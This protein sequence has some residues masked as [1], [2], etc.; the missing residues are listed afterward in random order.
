MAADTGSSMQT[1]IDGINRKLDI[2]LEELHVQRQAREQLEDLVDDLSIVG[3]DA[4]KAT[5]EKLDKAGIELDTDALES[6]VF[7]LIRNIDMLNA[8]FDMLESANDFMKDVAPVVNDMGLTV[9]RKTNE[10]DQKGYFEFLR[11]S[12]NIFDEVV[13]NFTIEDVRSLSENVVLMLQTVKNMTQPEM[14]K[15]MDNAI[16]VYK[17]MEVNEIPEYSLWKAMKE[18][19]KPEMKKGFGFIITFLKNLANQPYK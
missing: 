15:A 4:F 12:T 17:H 5:V 2:I 7:K 14:L 1:Q 3:K 6:L 10:L 19:R 13:S 16:S 18:L 11:E 8:S 9:I